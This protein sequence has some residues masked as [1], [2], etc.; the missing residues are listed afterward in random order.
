MRRLVAGLFA[1]LSLSL[2]AGP[3][4]VEKTPRLEGRAVILHPAAALTEA[5][6]AEL[7]QKG[8]VVR[9]AL[10][11]GRYLARMKEG[12]DGTADSRIVSV[13]PLSVEKKLHPSAVREAALGRPLIDTNVIFHRDVP[14][15]EARQA[16][17]EAGGAMDLFAVSYLPSRRIEVRV[18][19]TDLI[20]LAEDER[21]FAIS[22]PRNVKISAENAS[23]AALS[24]VTELHSAP[25]G[26]TGKGVNVSLFEL[27]PAQS[28]HVE[29]GGRLTVD[30]TGGSTS[31]RTHATHVAGTIGAAG[32]RPDA[33]GMAPEARIYQFCVDYPGNTCQAS[34]L[35]LKDEALRER[36]IVADNNSWGYVWGWEDGSPPIWNGG[37]VYW[38]AYDSMLSAP[39]DEI[40]IE[41][42][43]LFVHS[44]GNDG[45]LPFGLSLSEWKAHTHFDLDA[46]EDVPGTFC[47]SKN[48]SGTDCPATTCTGAC[49]KSL[50]HPL[51]P[52]DTVGTTASAK[53]VLAVGGVDSNL[54]I[55]S[56]GSR[57]PAKDGRVK[58]DVVARSVSVLST[59]PTDS[60]RTLTG[61]SMSSPAVTGIAAL[62]TEQW[63]RT[64][65]GATPRPAQLKA[66]IIAGAE[67]LGNPGPD[68]TFGFGLVNAK[69]S[70][71]LI[72]ADEGSGQRIRNLTFAQ[73]LQQSVEVPIV[74]SATQNL[75]IVLNWADP[76]IA[77]LGGDDVTQLALVNDLDLRVVDP[78]GKWRMPNQLMLKL[79]GTCHWIVQT[80]VYVPSVPRSAMESWPK[81]SRPAGQSP[82]VS[83]ATR[84]VDWIE[85]G[86]R[87]AVVCGLEEL[88]AQSVPTSFAT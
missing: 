13:E 51:T 82:L 81:H 71:D 22:G 16:I 49:E 68:Y 73:G 8:I 58:P 45:S 86:T 26:L 42:D 4:E 72:L 74:V 70:V 33:K 38:G 76:A 62:I 39:L 52:F 85:P 29:F 88:M 46:N 75:R 18:P 25:Y 31:D 34:W 10:P 77:L 87:T 48:A 1:V 84:I 56:S 37:D 27:A 66:L 44:A 40:S 24:H 47:V 20:A 83:S 14:F 69:S 12:A 5:D 23:S 43:V 32:L 67:D 80:T 59:V 36:G 11:G 50:H 61:T 57:G 64:F 60:Y 9:H 63:R 30:A 41:R 15:E 35:E 21:V 19:N 17:L 78:S 6:E 55:Y 54:D 7:A 79:L 3:R 28:T 53:N 2:L 65:G